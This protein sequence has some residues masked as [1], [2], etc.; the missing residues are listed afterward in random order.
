MRI[1][2]LSL[3]INR[4]MEGIP[5]IPTYEK[6]PT[7]CVIHSAINDTQLERLRTQGLEIA[8]DV[9]IGGSMNSHLEILGHIGTHIDAPCH[10]L[11]DGWSIDEVP[12]GHVVKKGRVIP[13][14][15]LGAESAVTAEEVLATGV[16]FDS[17]VIPILHTG[18][19]DR[20]WG[21][22]EFW[23]R[24]P[25]LDISAGE[26]MVERNVSA[27]AIDFFPEVPFWRMP[28]DP[29]MGPGP[30]HRKLLGNKTII[31][32]MVTN[33]GA[34]QSDDFLLVAVPLR[35]EKLDGSPARVFAMIE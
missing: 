12:L 18:W 28:R 6:Y 10:F 27:V 24:M 15:H 22:K 7:R 1:V 19:T 16:D 34:I 3:P 30:N 8:P 32:Q 20:T 23:A 11:P 25:Y 29:K 4:H 33:I 31:I 5:Q 14:T 17:S 26:L 21:T 9:K 13:L 35:L 2:D